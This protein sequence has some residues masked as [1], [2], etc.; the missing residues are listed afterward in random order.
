[1]CALLGG[2]A[3]T[4]KNT[5]LIQRYKNPA[6]EFNLR[7]GTTLAGYLSKT[8]DTYVLGITNILKSAQ[9]LELT[10]PANPRPKTTGLATARIDGH[11]TRGAAGKKPVEI[12]L[13]DG[14]YDHTSVIDNKMRYDDGPTRMTFGV[15]WDI[16]SKGYDYVEYT[17]GY[18]YSPDEWFVV[19]RATSELEWMYR[20]RLSLAGYYARYLYTVPLDIVSSPVQLIG[21]W[22]TPKW[23]E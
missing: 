11:P 4:Q 15:Y 13:M 21:I 22:L 8:D 19:A 20:S 12:E 23:E 7:S 10:F 9:T 17:V 2:C 6:T 1:M 3:F 14:R 5:E 16:R 18:K